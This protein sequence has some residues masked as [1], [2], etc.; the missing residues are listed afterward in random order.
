MLRS[1]S[2]SSSAFGRREVLLDAGEAF[3]ALHK[4]QALLGRP[5]LQV[6]FHEPAAFL[7][8]LLDL[9]LEPQVSCSDLL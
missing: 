6:L 3:Y 1:R 5:E 4:H 8:A 7:D 9:L 2:L